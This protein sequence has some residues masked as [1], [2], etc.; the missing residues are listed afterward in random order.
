MSMSVKLA[1]DL[2]ATSMR[3]NDSG[4][5]IAVPDPVLWGARPPWFGDAILGRAVE[6]RRARLATR[7][8]AL[9]AEKMEV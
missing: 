1:S 5:S 6:R 9:R 4:T 8:A 7:L 2:R 3:P